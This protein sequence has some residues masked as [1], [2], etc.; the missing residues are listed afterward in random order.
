MNKYFTLFFLAAICLPGCRSLNHK[1]DELPPDSPTRNR[2]VTFLEPGT[3]GLTT[4][5]VTSPQ[6]LMGA[7]AKASPL[8]SVYNPSGQGRT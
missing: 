3:D 5:V 7:N 2:T 8:N 6:S 4:C 1:P